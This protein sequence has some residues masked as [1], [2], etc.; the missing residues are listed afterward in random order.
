M[1]KDEWGV[2]RACPH[3]ATRFYDLGN[4]PMTCPACGETFTRESLLQTKMRG[5]AERTKPDLKQAEAEIA[6]VEDVE[7]LETEDEAA[8]VDDEL[9]E[10]DEDDNVDLDDIAD[11]PGGDDE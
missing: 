9:L 6:D 3:C 2:K 5:V 4:D 8:E 11:V 10:T 7:L 1:P